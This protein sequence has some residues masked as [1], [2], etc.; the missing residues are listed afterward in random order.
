MNHSPSGQRLEQAIANDTRTNELGI[1]VEVVDRR[2]TVRGEVASTERR[3]AVLCVVRERMPEAQVIDQ[4]TVSDATAP[5]R[6][7]EVVD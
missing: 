5:P 6:R 1:H 4:L 7:T 3:D 2:V